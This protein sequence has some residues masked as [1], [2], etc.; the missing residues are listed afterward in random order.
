MVLH[1]DSS[2]QMDEAAKA[3]LDQ[4]SEHT[5]TCAHKSSAGTGSIAV[6]IREFVD[7]QFFDS[8]RLD[9]FF[10]RT[11]R[12]EWSGTSPTVGDHVLQTH[13]ALLC[14]PQAHQGGVQVNRT[15]DGSRGSMEVC[16]CESMTSLTSFVNVDPHSPNFGPD[17][18]GMVV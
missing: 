4:T 5:A 14:C 8:S 10:L 15:P 11:S 7:D 2:A 3:V 18:C 9:F 12:R 17:V 6:V 16:C 13:R 1:V